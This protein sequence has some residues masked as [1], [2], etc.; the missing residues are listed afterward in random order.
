MTLLLQ[1]AEKSHYEYGNIKANVDTARELWYNTHSLGD[2]LD[3]STGLTEDQLT[4]YMVRANYNYQDKYLLTATARW[5]GSSRFGAD[6]K[7]GFFPSVGVAWR[8]TE[9]SFMQSVRN[10][11]SDLKVRGSFGVTGNQEI[12][13][14]QSLA[15]LESSGSSTNYVYNNTELT[16][17]AQTSM[18]VWMST[19]T[20]PK[21]CCCP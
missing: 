18:V 4:S 20:T 14:Y 8:A 10:V 3:Y 11:L 2:P 6:K 7:W 17:Y 21:T 9:E 13:N 19:P 5:D 1:S 12:G 15:R 16:G